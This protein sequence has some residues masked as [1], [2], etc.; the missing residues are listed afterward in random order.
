MSNKE[1][2][3]AHCWS[4]SVGHFE[5]YEKED[6]TL[7]LYMEFKD[8][9]KISLTT[10]DFIEEYNNAKDSIVGETISTELFK[11]IEMQQ[12]VEEL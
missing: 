8:G 10:T 11:K 4:V 6:K 2:L 12:I 1:K 5:V 9:H 3:L 7:A